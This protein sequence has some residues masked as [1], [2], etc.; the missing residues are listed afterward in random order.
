[1]TMHRENRGTYSWEMQTTKLLCSI[2]KAHLLRYTT[3][4]I[5]QLAKYINKQSTATADAMQV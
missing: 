1:M 4:N 3:C 2:L 5:Q